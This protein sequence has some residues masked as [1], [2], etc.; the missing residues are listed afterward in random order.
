MQLSTGSPTHELPIFQR[1]HAAVIQTAARYLSPRE[2]QTEA[3]IKNAAIVIK[4]GIQLKSRARKIGRA[5]EINL[6]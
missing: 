5:H 4:E 3:T 1:G 2:E 6:I